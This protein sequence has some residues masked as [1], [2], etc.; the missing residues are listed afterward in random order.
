MRELAAQ[1]LSVI[2]VFQPQMISEE[3]LPK[4]IESCLDKALHVRHGAI[5][6]VGEILIGLSGNSQINRKEVLE[7]AYKTLSLKERRLIEESQ[8]K[9]EFSGRYNQISSSNFL[10]VHV[11]EGSP[12]RTEV[13]H[14]IDR[15]D[16]QRLYR[17]KGGEIMRAGV[18]HLIFSLSLARVPLSEQERLYLFKTLLENFKH[19][20]IEIQEEA[21]KAFK[22]FCQTYL[23]PENPQDIL[24]TDK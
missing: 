20:N 3:I 15:I 24:N 10:N 16:K 1:S 2:S 14:I 11:P 7:K 13:K 8:N 5:L 12:L 23:S 18:C 22:A 21:T 9:S 19:P 17:G 6:G 4:L